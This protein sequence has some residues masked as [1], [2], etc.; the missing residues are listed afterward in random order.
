M[1]AISLSYDL[2]SHPF[3]LCFFLLKHPNTRAFL[4]AVLTEWWR[5]MSHEH[6]GGGG[7]RSRKWPRAELGVFS[8]VYKGRLHRS[9][10]L[11]MDVRGPEPSG[12]LCEEAYI[13]AA[14][15]QWHKT[16]K[17]AIFCLQRHQIVWKQ[18]DFQSSASCKTDILRVFVLRLDLF[19]KPSVDRKLSSEGYSFDT[20]YS[21]H[22]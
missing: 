1:P 18:L 7:T 10:D 9:T 5:V 14:I 15:G 22:W 20:A 16:W 6:S 8:H 12:Q 3:L 21:R 13:N 2:L 17:I 4:A 19:I 11:V